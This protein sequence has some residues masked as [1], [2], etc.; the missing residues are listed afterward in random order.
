MAHRESE[1]CPATVLHWNYR[2]F[3][4]FP[5]DRLRGEERE[6]TDIYLKE[7]H[8]TK[9]PIDIGRL[10]RLESLY[11]SGNHIRELPRELGLLS[12]L[13]CLDLSGNGLRRLPAEIGDVR[14]LKFLMLDENELHELPLR[15]AELKMLRYLSVCD[16]RLQWLPQRPVYNYHHCEFRFWRNKELRAL[17]YSLWYH[18]LRDQQTRSLN[19]GCLG[20]P[21]TKT[22]CRNTCHLKLHDGS[23]TEIDMPSKYRHV[24]NPHAN[25]PPTLAEMCKRLIYETLCETAK[26]LSDQQYSIHADQYFNAHNNSEDEHA[27]YEHR[28]DENGNTLTD[29]REDSNIITHP[30]GGN[31]N[32]ANGQ[33]VVTF[34]LQPTAHRTAK[35]RSRRKT[36]CRRQY[37]VTDLARRHF[38]FLP[39]DLL[40]SLCDGPISRC[41]NIICN[42]PIFDCVTFQFCLG[43]IL[44]IDRTEEAIL[45][46]AFCSKACAKSWSKGRRNLI[47]WTLGMKS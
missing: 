47:P 11:L 39:T 34:K 8:I 41:E 4:E 13:K 43:E 20:I 9:L 5:L 16:N 15:I 1:L 25:S 31:G 21:K 23:T 24:G 26:A 27:Y 14:G 32:I 17:P 35:D 22:L 44:L 2:G 45:S 3:R 33:S 10:E 19:I 29:S 30:R 7:N 12:R 40:K 42:R 46:A 37:T 36:V 6:V 28:S 38:D 18:M